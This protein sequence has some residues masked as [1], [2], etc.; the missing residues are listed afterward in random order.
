MGYLKG[1]QQACI[2]YND[3]VANQRGLPAGTITR[4]AHVIERGGDY[5]IPKRPDHQAT[6]GLIE[7]DLPEE[8][9]DSEIS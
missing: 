1:S 5:Y 4:W 9:H 2:A 8:E 3:H 6:E 7:S